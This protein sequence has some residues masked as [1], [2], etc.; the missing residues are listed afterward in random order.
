MMSQKIMLHG[1][2]QAA[3]VKGQEPSPPILEIAAC[4]ICATDRKAFAAPPATMQLPL[5]PGHEF[6][7]TLCG[8]GQRVVIWPA[9]SCGHCPLCVQGKAHL[10]ADIQLFGLHLDGGYQQTLF[11]PAG[12]AARAVF[13]EIPPRLSWLQATM[14]EPLGCVIHC[15]AMV[16]RPPATVLI[17][18]AGLMGCLAA[19]LIRQQWPECQLTVQDPDSV[20]QHS[21]DPGDG[22]GL[23]DVILL[24]CSDPEAVSQA[25]ARLQPGG[26]LLLF[27]GLP[28]DRNPLALDY[29]QIHRREQT[30]HGSYGCLPADMEKG[31]ALMASGDI[32]VDDLLNGRIGLAEACR[33]L[34]RPQES[35]DYKTVITMK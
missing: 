31:L 20:R 10:C 19:R 23:V 11:L 12:L 22:E 8:T 9:L 13:L 2:G 16:S 25:L 33:E 32:D 5:V 35:S 18:G 14:A 6:C 26:Q 15:L 29:N 34:A 3:L 28:R 4:G 30:L 1:P 24:A 27:S 21:F 7:G 17:F